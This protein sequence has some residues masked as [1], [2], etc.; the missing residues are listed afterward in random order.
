MLNC[1]KNSVS[2][3]FCGKCETNG[4]NIKLLPFMRSYLEKE[5]NF[6]KKHNKTIK[7][8]RIS[9]TIIKTTIS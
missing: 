6:D 9:F 7:K 8:N 2:N 3:K 5:K 4:S 1:R